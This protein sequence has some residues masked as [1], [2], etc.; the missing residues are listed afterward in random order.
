[1]KIFQ[2]IG[3]F[4]HWDASAVLP[5][6]G[7]QAGRFSKD[8]IF[9][10][11]PDHVFEGWGFDPTREGD[12]RFIQPQPPEG[13]LYDEKSGTFYPEDGEKPSSQNKTNAQ[14]AKE[15]KDLSDNTEALKEQFVQLQKAFSE[16]FERIFGGV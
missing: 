10:E 4:C 6:L 15:L 3:G 13:W 11:A 7:D 8:M 2:I 1:M 12:D 16:L 5:T 9:V 14:L